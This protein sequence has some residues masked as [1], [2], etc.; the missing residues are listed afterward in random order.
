MT[1]GELHYM[2]CTN[3]DCERAYCVGRREAEDRYT[4]LKILE[5]KL[6][7]AKK[8]IEFYAEL[9]CIGARKAMKEIWDE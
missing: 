4:R 7:K 2:S 9:N 5:A 3:E 1:K 8:A 6:D